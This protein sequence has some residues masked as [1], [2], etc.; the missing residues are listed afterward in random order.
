MRVLFDADSLIQYLGGKEP[1][2]TKIEAFIQMQ[3]SRIRILDV[4]LVKVIETLAEKYKIPK[5]T[6]CDT[7][8]GLIHN[9]H[10][11][12]NNILLL[13]TLILYRDSNINIV[14]AYVSAN[15]HMQGLRLYTFDKEFKKVRTIKDWLDYHK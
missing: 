10:V 6:I 7:A 5:D 1:A 15:A 11:V 3:D 4:V 13:N 12:C 8:E 14:T 9:S 2:A